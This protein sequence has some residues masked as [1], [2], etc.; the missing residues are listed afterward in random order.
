MAR[1]LTEKEIKDAIAEGFGKFEKEFDGIKC[2]VSRILSLLEGDD[3]MGT[4]GLA[5][6]VQK[7]I[8]HYEGWERE[9][10][11]KV[12]NEIIEK[13]KIGKAIVALII[14]SG[15][16]SLVNLINTISEVLSKFLS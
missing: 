4:E 12:V 14:T 6:R 15:A 5:K 8:E 1:E 7:S 9:G 11:W 2:D 16:I 3:K 10:K 13:Y